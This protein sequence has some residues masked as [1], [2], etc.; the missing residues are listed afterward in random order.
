MLQHS[1][2]ESRKEDEL[3]CPRNEGKAGG[4]FQMRVE[5]TYPHFF[6]LPICIQCFLK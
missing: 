6:C 2:N 1:D 5:L 3:E 4:I